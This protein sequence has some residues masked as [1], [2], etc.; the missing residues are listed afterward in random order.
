MSTRPLSPKQLAGLT[1]CDKAL[2]QVR[3][4][5][6]QGWSKEDHNPCL[7]LFWSH[8]NELSVVEKGLIIYG[9]RVIIPRRARG[10]V[11]DTHSRM[12][13]MKVVA[14]FLCCLL[15]LSPPPSLSVERTH[16]FQHS[17]TLREIPARID[18]N[19][20]SMFR[21]FSHEK[22][23]TVTIAVAI[24]KHVYVGITKTIYTVITVIP[25]CVHVIV[26][27]SIRRIS[28]VRD[29]LFGVE[30]VSSQ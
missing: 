1:S 13:S 27:M 3:K 18:H 4:K 22:F 8:R 2:R 16:S 23:E 20:I 19:K 6:L 28:Q 12:T 7:K 17:H 26:K 21:N 15:P 5:I 29:V 9:R 10:A 11:H 24:L 30:K 25:P 14:Q